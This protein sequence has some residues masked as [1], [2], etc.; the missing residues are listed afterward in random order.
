M[1]DPVSMGDVAK[2]VGV[3]CSTVSKVLAG[4]GGKGRIALAT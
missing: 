1:S 4:K 3:N 2:A